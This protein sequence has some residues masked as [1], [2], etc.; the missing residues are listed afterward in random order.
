MR[1]TF[2]NAGTSLSIGI[3]F[4]LMV[5][6]LSGTLPHALDSGLQAQGVSAGIAGQIS[7]LPPV[8]SLFAA[9]LGFNPIEQLLGPTGALSQVSAGQAA[10]LTGGHFFPSLIAGAFHHGLAVVFGAAAVMSVI[11]ALASLFRGQKFVHDDEAT[12]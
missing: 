6:G 2:F 5:L 8:S 4:S 1:A 3:F 10:T 7:H 11:A 12:A 9:F